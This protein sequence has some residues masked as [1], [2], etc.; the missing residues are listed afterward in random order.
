MLL[1]VVFKFQGLPAPGEEIVPSKEPVVKP[2]A[3][4]NKRSTVK[5]P[6]APANRPVHP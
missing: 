5:L 6:A 1:P 2:V 4:L 3:W